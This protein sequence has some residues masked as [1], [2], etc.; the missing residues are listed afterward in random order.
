MSLIAEKD[1]PRLY[2]IGRPSQYGI[3][4]LEVGESRIFPCV[5]EEEARRRRNSI[6]SLASTLRPKQFKIY[7]IKGGV[8]YRRIA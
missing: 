4:D 3:N 1:P 7:V 2:K 6:G 8:F 5:T